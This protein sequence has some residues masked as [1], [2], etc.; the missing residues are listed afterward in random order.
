MMYETGKSISRARGRYRRYNDSICPLEGMNGRSRPAKS[1]YRTVLRSHESLWRLQQEKVRQSKD[2]ASGTNREHRKNPKMSKTLTVRGVN[3]I[4]ALVTATYNRAVSRTSFVRY[5]L[6]SIPF[7]ES[8]TLITLQGHPFS[9]PL[10][11]MQCG[12]QHDGTKRAHLRRS[13]PCVLEAK[14]SK[15]AT[16]NGSVHDNKHY[17]T[18][19]GSKRPSK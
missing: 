4:N 9:R 17:F 10:L 6:R 7:P 8:C 12:G 11:W 13:L 5:L 19:R 18:C 16:K 14:D 2:T 15:G 3:A 1:V